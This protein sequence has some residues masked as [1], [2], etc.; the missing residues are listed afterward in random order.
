MA[1]KRVEERGKERKEKEKGNKSVS[2]TKRNDE[3][4]TLTSHSPAIVLPTRGAEHC[5]SS[6]V[7]LCI[8]GTS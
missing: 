6:R 2:E 1:T 3:I 5:Q 4:L 7:I 8:P